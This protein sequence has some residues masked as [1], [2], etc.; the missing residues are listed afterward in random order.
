MAPC[1]KLR[2]ANWWANTAAPRFTGVPGTV[3]DHRR[4]WDAMHSVTLE[5]L[6]QAGGVIAQRAVGTFGLDCSSVAL[7]MTI[8][9][10]ID[11]RRQGT[12]RA[13]RQGQAETQRLAAGGAGPG[14]HPG[15]GDPADLARL[16]RQQAGRHPVPGHDHPAQS[17]V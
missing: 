10:F 4:F 2:F 11:T 6:E 15:R 7:D 8:R 17:P 1:S 5:Q 14:G 12:D 3:L 13:A 16:P 9:H